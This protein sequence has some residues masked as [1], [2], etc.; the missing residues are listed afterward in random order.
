M[1]YNNGIFDGKYFHLKKK[2]VNK[3]DYDNFLEKNSIIRY[4][5]LKKI[6]LIDYGFGIAIFLIFFMVEIGLP[7]LESYGFLDK[8]EDKPP[9]CFFMFYIEDILN[10]IIGDY[11]FPIA[12]GVLIIVLAVMLITTI[13]KILLNYEKYIKIKF[14]I[15]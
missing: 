3:K 10:I 1:D 14:M 4:K 12:F 6:K 5:S 9:F 2:L 15:E 11:T 13:S 8:L 7:T